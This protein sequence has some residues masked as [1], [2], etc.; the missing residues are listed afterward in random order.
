[1][2]TK[3][4]SD[5]S[6]NSKYCNK[7]CKKVLLHLYIYCKNWAFTKKVSS[8][9]ISHSN[10]HSYWQEAGLEGTRP[11][12]RQYYEPPYPNIEIPYKR[13]L[14]IACHEIPV[15]E[16]GSKAGSRKYQCLAWCQEVLMSGMVPGSTNVWH[17]ARKWPMSGMVPG[18][19]QCLAW[20]QEILMSDKVPGSD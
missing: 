4:I 16:R 13:V 11:S 8:R 6:L 3:E 1:M 7:Y 9:K 20:C 17:G 14:I 18:S 12:S 15:P 19:D 10:E 5:N 2:H